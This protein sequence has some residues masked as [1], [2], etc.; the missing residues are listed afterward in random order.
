MSDEEPRSAGVGAGG[1]PSWR[2]EK[3]AGTAH[4]TQHSS[5]PQTVMVLNLNLSSDSNR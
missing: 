2:R 3:V 4:S 1:I 5:Q